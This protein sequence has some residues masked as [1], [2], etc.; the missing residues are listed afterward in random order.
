[1]SI[2]LHIP[3]ASKHIPDEY[4]K[5]FTLSKTDLQFELQALIFGVP[6]KKVVYYRIFGFLA[7]TC[8]GVLIQTST[9]RE[10]VRS[11]VYP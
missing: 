3:H 11:P 8:E 9:A 10:K 6:Y 4:L 2:I 1:M 7:S 5:Y